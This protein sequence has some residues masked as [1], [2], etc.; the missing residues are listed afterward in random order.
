MKNAALPIT[1]ITKDVSSSSSSAE[2]NAQ[3]VIEEETHT[4]ISP[5]ESPHKLV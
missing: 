2:E 3:N 5:L 4:S 1:N